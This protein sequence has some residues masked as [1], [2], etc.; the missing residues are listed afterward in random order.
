MILLNKCRSCK[1]LQQKVV[2][3]RSGKL[4]PKCSTSVNPLLHRHFPLQ[5]TK[6]T[7]VASGDRN[8]TLTLSLGKKFEVTYVSMQ[9]CNARPDSMA[10][11][12]SVDYGRTW[13]PFQFY[14][15]YG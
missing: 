8:V 5:G 2:E 11:Y 9:F 12:K 13:V 15:R 14:S 7:S 6:L 1:C 10:I 4:R 3:L